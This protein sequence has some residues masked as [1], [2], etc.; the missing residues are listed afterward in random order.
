M[1]AVHELTAVIQPVV[2]QMGYV[3]WGA[4]FHGRGH[5]AMLRVFIDHSDGIS[6][7]DCSAVSGQL[8]SVLDIEDVIKQSYTLE[9]SSPG[10]ERSLFRSEH[11]QRYIGER[12][13]VRS[14]F[15]LA[16]RKNFSGYLKSA[17]GYSIVLDL[18]GELIEIPLN[19]I[20]LAKLVFEDERV[21]NDRER[22]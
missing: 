9:V 5:R 8:G 7:D 18:G 6:L 14:R 15:P 4:E 16:N 20:K 21:F 3:F 22:K 1:S 10:I 12:I 2:E 13:K 19:A 11:Y 17:D